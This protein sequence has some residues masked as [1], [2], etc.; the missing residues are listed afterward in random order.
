ML[1][2]AQCNPLVLNLVFFFV[3]QVNLCELKDIRP[4]K[5]IFQEALADDFNIDLLTLDSRRRLK[6]D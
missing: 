6:L 2:I 3:G 5:V 1:W 4:N